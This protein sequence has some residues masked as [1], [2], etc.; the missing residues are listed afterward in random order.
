MHA[1]LKIL[2]FLVL[3]V[4]LVGAGVFFWPMLKIW[5][6]GYRQGKRI[7]SPTFEHEDHKV[8]D[9]KAA[10]AAS[11]KFLGLPSVHA[12]QTV[13]NVPVMDPEQAGEWIKNRPVVTATRIISRLK[14]GEAPGDLIELQGGYALF[15]SNGKVKVMTQLGL[16]TSEETALERE[17]KEAVE[18]GDPEIPNFQG[19]PWKIM[20]AC[21]DHAPRFAGD[22]KCSSIQVLSVHPNL[23]ETGLISFLP[24]NLLDKQEADYYDMRA[25]E[26][27]GNRA[28]IFMYAGGAWTCFMGRNLT[29]EENRQ[30][31]AM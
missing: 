25:V 17:R 19:V 18:K 13:T 11:L 20:S 10:Q 14:Q 24:S 8:Q 4:I 22:K 1:V 5:I 30:L 29:D 6:E 28:M 31:G 21:G 15:A 16:T 12:G 7:K 2:E 3:I 27:D 9:V 23:G 26:V